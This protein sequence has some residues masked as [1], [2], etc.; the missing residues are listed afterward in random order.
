VTIIIALQHEE[1]V[2]VGCDGLRTGG[3]DMVLHDAMKWTINSE[4]LSVGLS[5][6]PYLGDKI[7]SLV[8][9]LTVHQ[10]CDRLRN[11]FRCDDRWPPEIKDGIMPWWDLNLLVTDKQ[12][13]WEIAGT[14]YPME[15]PP[16]QPA[17]VGA[18]YKYALGAMLSR[19][20][21]RLGK[22]E[23]RGA[24]WGTAVVTEG[25]EAACHYDIKCG[26][27]LRV[28]TLSP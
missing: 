10:F 21:C 1:G 3:D 4:G 9:G 12:K 24:A 14:L 7:D 28:E 18:G 8:E 11:Y 19:M 5:G 17:A 2:T 22:A 27:D 20:S 13:V 23:L 15:I 6:S 25:L 16:G 26:G